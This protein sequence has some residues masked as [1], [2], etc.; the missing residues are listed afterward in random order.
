MRHLSLGSLLLRSAVDIHVCCRASA[1][2]RRGYMIEHQLQVME[3]IRVGFAGSSGVL[4]FS[5]KRAFTISVF[6]VRSQRILCLSQ[7]VGTL[8]SIRLIVTFL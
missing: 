7:S 8:C 2:I 3:I 6:S 1:L 5:E 4:S